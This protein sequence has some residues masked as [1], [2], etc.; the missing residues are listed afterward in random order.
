MKKRP[1]LKK[2]TLFALKLLKKSGVKKVTDIQIIKLLGK[3]NFGEVYYGI[4][5]VIKKINKKNNNKIIN[6]KNFFW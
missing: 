1:A 4:W 6:F 5:Q 3:G 2:G